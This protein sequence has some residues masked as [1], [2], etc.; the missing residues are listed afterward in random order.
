MIYA[1]YGIGFGAQQPVGW[2]CVGCRVAQINMSTV[3]LACGMVLSMRGL[4]AHGMEQSIIPEGIEIRQSESEFYAQ[5]V[6]SDLTGKALRRAYAA[7]NRGQEPFIKIEALAELIEA[8]RDSLTDGYC[9]FVIEA[10]FRSSTRHDTVKWA[11]SGPMILRDRETMHYSPSRNKQE[12]LNSYD[13][14][15]ER[16][17]NRDEGTGS[18]WSFT[19]YNFFILDTTRWPTRC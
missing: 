14:N 16:R 8:K 3:M 11:F 13:G 6:D 9:S 7:W 10:Q 4:L 12:V 19:G 1:A 17:Y 15:Y 5:L 18:I 2:H